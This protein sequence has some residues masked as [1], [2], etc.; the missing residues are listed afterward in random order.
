M[1]MRSVSFGFIVAIPFY[2]AVIHDQIRILKAKT[3]ELDQYPQITTLPKGHGFLNPSEHPVRLARGRQREWRQIN[4]PI[5]VKKHL[6]LISLYT[7]CKSAD[8]GI[9]TFLISK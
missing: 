3:N 6:K 2:L 1:K 8:T 5:I 7:V 4:S 9:I